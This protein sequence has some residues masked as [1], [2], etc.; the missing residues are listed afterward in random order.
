MVLNFQNNP[1]VMFMTIVIVR[2]IIISNIL[3]IF[4]VMVI[5]IRFVIVMVIVM[6]IIVMVIVSGIG[7]AMVSC[8]CVSCDFALNWKVKLNTHMKKDH[9]SWWDLCGVDVNEPASL[10]QHKEGW[11]GPNFFPCDPC[12]PVAKLKEHLKWHMRTDHKSSSREIEIRAY[13]CHR[14]KDAGDT[15]EVNDNTVDVDGLAV[16]TEVAKVYVSLTPLAM[17]RTAEPGTHD[18]FTVSENLK[19]KIILIKKFQGVSS[20][21]VMILD[22][23]RVFKCEDAGEMLMM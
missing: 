20:L 15:E 22:E 21:P 12:G 10:K 1:I 6:A 8:Q 23:S 3:V 4:M 18:L 9:G 17:M 7:M 19:N 14:C 13:K 2:V 16:K 5:F 11:C